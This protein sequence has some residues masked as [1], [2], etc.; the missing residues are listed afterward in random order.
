M[1]VWTEERERSVLS[2]EDILQSS[3]DS[4]GIVADATG[5]LLGNVAGETL[6]F[7]ADLLRSKDITLRGAG[8]GAYQTKVLAQQSPHIAKVIADGRIPKHAFKV[9]NLDELEKAWGSKAER[10]VVVP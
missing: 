4:L 10:L 6:E 1:D 7:R 2:G 8:P 5:M 3:K 9:V